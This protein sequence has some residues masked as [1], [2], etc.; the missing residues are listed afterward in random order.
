[1]KKTYKFLIATGLILFSFNLFAAE[2]T[3][4]LPDVKTVLSG[5]NPEQKAVGPDFTDDAPLPSTS[6]E[7]V[8]DVPKEKPAS[9]VRE[10]DKGDFDFFK[11]Y[12]KTGIIQGAFPFNFTGKVK[13]QKNESEEKSDGLLEISPFFLDFSYVSSIFTRDE[14]KNDSFFRRDADL[15]VKAPLFYSEEKQWALDA[16]LSFFDIE[17]G[18][19]NRGGKTLT[20][21]QRNVKLDYVYAREFSNKLF[22]V[23]G[24][25]GFYTRSALTTDT[26]ASWVDGGT[27]FY[28]DPDIIFKM[29]LQNEETAIKGVTVKLLNIFD[30]TAYSSAYKAVLEA[31]ADFGFGKNLINVDAGLCFALNVEDTIFNIAP[32]LIT[33]SYGTMEDNFYIRVKSGVQSY[34]PKTYELEKQYRFAAM[35]TATKDTSD[36]VANVFARYKIIDD[37]FITN[38]LDFKKTFYSHGLWVP[39]YKGTMTDGLYNFVQKDRMDLSLS[40]GLDWMY[41]YMKIWGLYKINFLDAGPL[42]SVHYY[43]AGMSFFNG[44]TNADRWMITLTAKGS[45]GGNDDVPVLNA[46]VEKRF[47]NAVALEIS[48]DDLLK[49]VTNNL[50][51]YAGGYVQESGKIALAL[52]LNL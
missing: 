38:E 30:Q 24:D 20:V 13:I 31:E 44:F 35:N 32:F 2:S 3:I 17:N 40:V 23:R 11:D 29:D 25:A 39:D 14:A 18:M 50:R 49:F 21:S 10:A 5:D 37:L 36:I 28:I 46:A 52:K 41:N 48:A 6:G 16:G 1:M 22:Q 12:S 47:N 43:E 19:Q 42:D 51:N 27:E 9:L 8:P 4:S 7:L 33:Y 15:E 45:L 26:V 34:L